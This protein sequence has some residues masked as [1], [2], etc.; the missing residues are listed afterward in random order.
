MKKSID[1]IQKRLRAVKD[2]Y[3]FHTAA[4]IR[5]VEF[6]STGVRAIDRIANGGFPL[7]RIVEIYGPYSSGK[8]LLCQ[9]AVVQVQKVGGIPI[10]VDRE[11][12]YDARFAERQGVDSSKL[13]YDKKLKTVEDI[14]DYI[15][16]SIEK[17]RKIDKDVIIAAIWDSV[18]AANTRKELGR[19]KKMRDEEELDTWD[20]DM[21]HRAKMIGE[22]LRKLTG[23]M[24]DRVVVL[25]VNQIRSK[26][27]AFY[28]NPETTTGG[29]ALPFYTSL[30]LRLHQGTLPSTLNEKLI[31]DG[32]TVTGS[33]VVCAVTKSK[34]GPPFRKCEVAQSFEF[35]FL[36]WPGLYELML[37]EGVISEPSKGKF[38][39]EKQVLNKKEFVEFVE[40]HPNVMLAEPRQLPRDASDVDDSADVEE[41]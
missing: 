27:G 41:A 20:K 21:G 39:Y 10:F 38:R 25:I 6:I 11:H 22:G 9:C 14:F 15:M 36:E 29:Q 7:G 40:K 31:K 30:R 17:I 24:D 32:N 37:W 12:T 18:A 1:A 4:E 26:V 34:V 8:T 3:K 23:I 16:G 33:R 5:P 13:Y 28:G 35:G 19:K 2:A